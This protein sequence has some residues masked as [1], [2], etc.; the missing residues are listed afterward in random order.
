MLKPPTLKK[1]RLD[2]RMKMLNRLVLIGV[3]IL[4]P[5]Y[6]IIRFTGG[7]TEKLQELPDIIDRI[8]TPIVWEVPEG[9]VKYLSFFRGAPEEGFKFVLVHVRMEARMKIGFPIVPKCFRLVDDQNT[10][11]YP[12]GHSPIFIEHSDER[13]LEQGEVY[14]GDLL[15]E[16]PRERQSVNLLFD[17]YKE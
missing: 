6:L 13:F 1:E 14:E 7:S 8:K 17:R 4:L 11:Y 5:L 3:F 9:G 16:I 10:R 15:F 2:A 12:L